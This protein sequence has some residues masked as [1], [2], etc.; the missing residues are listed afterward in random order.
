MLRIPV[1]DVA[2]TRDDSRTRR[3]P[4]ITETCMNNGAC[5]SKGH[6]NSRDSRGPTCHP[7]SPFQLCK[8]CKQSIFGSALS[9]EMSTPDKLLCSAHPRD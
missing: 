7:P 8:S 1:L 2:V 9:S 5:N 3:T 4:G 6:R